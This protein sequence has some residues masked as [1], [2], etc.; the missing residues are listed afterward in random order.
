[1]SLWAKKRWN[2]A[3]LSCWAWGHEPRSQEAGAGWTA[4]ENRLKASTWGEQ[5]GDR[6][7]LSPEKGPQGRKSIQLSNKQQN[8]GNAGGMKSWTG[9]V[10]ERVM[11]LDSSWETQFKDSSDFAYLLAVCSPQSLFEPQF[12]W[13][14]WQG[15]GGAVILVAQFCSR[16]CDEG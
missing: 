3:L 7:W 6:S 14:K 15:G 9:K 10:K 2:R 5:E 4:E 16:G 1:M 12:Q 11:C 8:T 13:V